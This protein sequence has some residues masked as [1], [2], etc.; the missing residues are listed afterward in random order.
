[1]KLKFNKRTIAASSVDRLG[2]LIVKIGSYDDAY[3]M[4]ITVFSLKEASKVCLRCIENEGLGVRDWRGGEV[5]STSTRLCVAVIS[6]NG[7][8]WYPSHRRNPEGDALT[9]PNIEFD[10]NA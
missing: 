10:L 6:Y 8:A 1:M 2:P 9:N 4:D 3:L 7:R 5:I